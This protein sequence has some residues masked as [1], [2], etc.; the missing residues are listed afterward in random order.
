[1]LHPGST[2]GS[3]QNRLHGSDSMTASNTMCSALKAEL[4]AILNGSRRLVE[5]LDNRD[6]EHL[7]RWLNDYTKYR[8]H[9][10]VWKQIVDD[11]RTHGISVPQERGAIFRELIWCALEARRT[12]E[13]VADGN[14]PEW[15]H[16]QRHRTYLI[17]LATKADELARYCREE[18]EQY[19]GIGVKFCERVLR[20]LVM[21]SLHP[22]PGRAMPVYELRVTGRLLRELHENEATLL[23]GL[24]R[25]EPA[26]PTTVVSRQSGGK[27]R[28]PR[29]R[30][31]KA[32]INCMT[33][34]LRGLCGTGVDGK[35]HRDVIALLTHIAFLDAD[36]VDKEYVRK[37][38]VRKA[39]KPKSLTP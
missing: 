5:K 27:G 3:R 29:S 13:Q 32:F 26:A 14:D 7:E 18:I 31:L 17:D 15:Q 30:P 37:A 21:Q 9:E 33:S 6:R 36:V 25:Q 28:H 38:L 19:S 8:E 39:K 23:R 4:T 11:A 1:V 35:P 22:L 20:P 24:A 2:K 16:S 12:A 34:H 10:L